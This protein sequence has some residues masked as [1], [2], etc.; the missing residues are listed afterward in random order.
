MLEL[1]AS[2][3]LAYFGIRLVVGGP[4]PFILARATSPRFMRRE[5]F[6]FQT[7]FSRHRRD[8]KRHMEGHTPLDAAAHMSWELRYVREASAF[9]VLKGGPRSAATYYHT[10]K[11]H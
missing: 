4:Q 6:H 3:C 8:G 5:F 11:C 2:W 10:T 9:S 7:K 1:L